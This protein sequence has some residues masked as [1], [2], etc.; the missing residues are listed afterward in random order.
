MDRNKVDLYI[1]VNSKYFN[2]K[3]IPQ[4]RQ[5]LMNMPEEKFDILQVQT[6]DLKDPVKIFMASLTVGTLGVDRFLIGDVGLGILK[7][8]TLGGCGLWTIV[9]WFFITKA[10]K[11]RN[12]EMFLTVG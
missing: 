4:I 7:L 9:D 12:L 11:S 3:D 5:I 6:S 8:I 2:A 1:T 10:T